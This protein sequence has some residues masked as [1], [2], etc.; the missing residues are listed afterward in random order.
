[1]KEKIEQL[2][3]QYQEEQKIFLQE[4]KKIEQENLKLQAKIEAVKDLEK[5]LLGEVL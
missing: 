3:Q 5:V 2:V 1:M 4:H